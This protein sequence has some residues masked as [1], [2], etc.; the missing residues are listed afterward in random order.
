MQGWVRYSPGG[1]YCDVADVGAGV[2]TRRCGGVWCSG[3]VSGVVG[4]GMGVVLTG[5]RR[6]AG[7]LRRGG[8]GGPVW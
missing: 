8:F 2:V 6:V 3:C 4:A 5:G 1:R 7:T